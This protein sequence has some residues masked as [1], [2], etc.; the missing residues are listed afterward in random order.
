MT[1]KIILQWSTRK[2]NCCLA[3]YEPSIKASFIDHK[4]STISFATD[5]VV[6]S[7]SG[8]VG[9][10]DSQSFGQ[11]VGWSVNDQLTIQLLSHLTFWL[12]GGTNYKVKTATILTKQKKLQL[13]VKTI[14][15]PVQGNSQDTIIHELYHSQLYFQAPQNKLIL[16]TVWEAWRH[17]LSTNQLVCLSETKATIKNPNDVKLRHLNRSATPKHVLKFE[18]LVR[19][20]VTDNNSVKMLFS[21]QILSKQ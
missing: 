2:M 16:H 13:Y 21:L 1:E 5:S 14:C 3:L 12:V 4:N 6:R 19:Q 8:L 18:V 10:S 17:F 15:I 20:F 7:V 11:S 9:W